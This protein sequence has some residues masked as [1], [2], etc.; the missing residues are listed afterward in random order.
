[1]WKR[2]E[3]LGGTPK[4]QKSLQISTEVRESQMRSEKMSH[5]SASESP[6]FHLTV[7]KNPLK[8][9][10]LVLALAFGD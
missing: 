6:K 8:H 9:H 4:E 3:W 10:K 7:I 5:E 1:M 2:S